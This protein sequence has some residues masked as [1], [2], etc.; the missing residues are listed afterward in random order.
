M[1]FLTTRKMAIE[2]ESCPCGG[3]PRLVFW[4]EYWMVRCE[5]C[6]LRVAGFEF[7]EDAIES[8]YRVVKTK[9]DKDNP[10]MEGRT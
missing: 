2:K 10:K 1:S 4:G 6:P 3:T 8:F 9:G 5:S 7:P